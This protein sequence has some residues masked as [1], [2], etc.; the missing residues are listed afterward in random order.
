VALSIGNADAG[1]RPICN[2]N[3]NYRGT[4][5][6]PAAHDSSPRGLDAYFGNFLPGQINTSNWHGVL[7]NRFTILYG[8]FIKIYELLE[9]EIRSTKYL[10]VHY[11]IAKYIVIQISLGCN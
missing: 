3:S 8:H 1:S 9:L 11:E 4:I 7:Y 2:Y 5:S 6:G 10:K